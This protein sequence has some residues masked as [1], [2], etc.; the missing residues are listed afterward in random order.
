MRRRECE[1][2]E[3]TVDVVDH[4]MGRALEIMRASAVQPIK[5]PGKSMGGLIGGEAKKLSRRR[6]QGEEHLRR[7]AGQGYDLCHGCFGG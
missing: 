4:R 2:G 5:T 1:L 3:T 7:R 6:C